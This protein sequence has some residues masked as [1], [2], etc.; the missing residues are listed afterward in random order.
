MA[1]S[2][3]SVHF[4]KILTLEDLDRKKL[5]LPRLEEQ[6]DISRKVEVRAESCRPSVIGR[7]STAWQQEW[8]VAAFPGK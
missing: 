4:R 2:P 3:K 5:K 8:D 7:V 6:L 1:N